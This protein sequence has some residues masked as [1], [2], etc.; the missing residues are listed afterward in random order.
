MV[1]APELSTNWLLMIEKFWALENADMVWIEQPSSGR[2]NG[3]RERE[4]CRSC[5]EKKTQRARG[6]LMSAHSF[7]SGKCSNSRHVETILWNHK[8]I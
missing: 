3:G 8:E 6:V 4:R 2:L 5:C 1:V 7:A